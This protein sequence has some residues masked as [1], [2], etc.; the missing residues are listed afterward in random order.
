MDIE[1]VEDIKNFHQLI[2]GANR[3]ADCGFNLDEVMN[4]MYVLDIVELCKKYE[5]ENSITIENLF[6]TNNQEA[7][8]SAEEALADFFDKKMLKCGV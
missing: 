8:L 4:I 6:T 5:I 2:G 1:L 7:I 3:L